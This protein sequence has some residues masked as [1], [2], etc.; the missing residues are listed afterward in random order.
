M[1][2]CVCLHVWKMHHGTMPRRGPLILWNYRW[3][4]A[5]TLVL[6]TKPRSSYKRLLRPSLQLPTEFCFNELSREYQGTFLI[7]KPTITSQN[8]LSPRRMCF[9]TGHH[10]HKSS[11]WFDGKRF[12]PKAS[13]LAWPFPLWYFR[14][15]LQRVAGFFQ[16][17]CFLCP[18]KY[19]LEPWFSI[20]RHTPSHTHSLCSPHS[21]SVSPTGQCGFSPALCGLL[22]FPAL[23]PWLMLA[24]WTSLPP[25]PVPRE[26][27]S[28]FKTTSNVL[29][30][31][32]NPEAIPS[33]P[34]GSL[35]HVSMQALPSSSQ[36][37][38]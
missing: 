4:W 25:L 30:K 17:D 23:R 10:N 24:S 31:P 18:S 13:L 29:C 11:R 38:S 15:P 1:C 26:H 8:S 6:G 3:L 22:S 32:N 14:V 16:T 20:L 9:L 19:T 21:V 7:V 28:F 34:L 12:I 37:M 27:S 5:T 35:F 33:S 36:S 2:V